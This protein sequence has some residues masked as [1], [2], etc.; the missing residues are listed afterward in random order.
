MLKVLR[1]VK[2]QQQLN[3]QYLSQLNYNDNSIYFRIIMLQT[4]PLSYNQVSSWRINGN[5]EDHRNLINHFLVL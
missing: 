3:F 4:F 1:K 2:D 5:T